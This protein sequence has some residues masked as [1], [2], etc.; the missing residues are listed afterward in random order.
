M[1][2][3][4]FVIGLNELNRERLKRLRGAEEIEFHGVLDPAAVYETQEFDIPA[5][6]RQA[7][8]ELSGFDGTIDAIVGYMDFPVSTML[9]ILCRKFNVRSPS[10]ESLLKCEHKYWSRVVQRE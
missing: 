9:P 1:K 4:V 7:E 6:L 3:N 10:L 8:A 2:K 5:M